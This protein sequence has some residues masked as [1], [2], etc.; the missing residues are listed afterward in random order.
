MLQSNV[1]VFFLTL[2]VRLTTDTETWQSRE[3]G[4]SIQF[5]FSK[6]HIGRKSQ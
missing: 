5:L 6:L 2:D 3:T 1:S 4:S